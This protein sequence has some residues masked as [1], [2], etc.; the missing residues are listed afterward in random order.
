MRRIGTIYL[1]TKQDDAIRS[2]ISSASG[3]MLNWDLGRSTLVSTLPLVESTSSTS[4]HVLGREQNGR[5]GRQAQA[6]ILI[7]Y[8]IHTVCMY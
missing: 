3:L 1:E 5:S 7:I 4:S 8:C 2:H 6:L